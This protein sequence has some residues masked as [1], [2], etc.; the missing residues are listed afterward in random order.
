MASISTTSDGRRIIQFTA[1][2]GRRHSIRFGKISLRVA[3]AVKLRVEAMNVAQITGAWEG[4]LANTSAAT[5]TDALSI[6]PTDAAAMQA[7]IYF[8][9]GALFML[10]G[11][12]WLI[13][14][15][16]LGTALTIPIEELGIL[17]EASLMLWLLV[18]G[19]NAERWSAAT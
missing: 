14:L 10:A 5:I 15:S 6:D 16:P 7:A 13:F 8:F 1:G 4:G 12:G 18:F 17:A 19:L 11:L 2:D 9:G 3:Q